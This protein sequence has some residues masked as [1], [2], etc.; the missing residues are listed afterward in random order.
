M[1]AHRIKL[2]LVVPKNLNRKEVE[3]ILKNVISSLYKKQQKFSSIRRFLQSSTL[4]EE[5][6]EEIQFSENTNELIKPGKPKLSF[7]ES[8]VRTKKRKISDAIEAA[9][10]PNRV[11]GAGISLMK[12]DLPNI[13]KLIEFLHQNK[14][15]PDESIKL[16]EEN[17]SQCQTTESEGLKLFFDLQLSKDRYQKLRNFSV[18]KGL[19]KLIPTYKTIVAA[20]MECIPESLSVGDNNFQCDTLDIVKHTLKRIISVDEKLSETFFNLDSI[21]RI[22]FEIKTGMDG[23]DSKTQYAHTFNDL[24]LSDKHFTVSTM[25]PLKVFVNDE[26]FYLNNKP[27]SSKLTRPIYFGFEK[28]STTLIKFIGDKIKNELKFADSFIIII[29]NSEYHIELEIENNM[30]MMDQK[31]VNALVD[32]NATLRCNICLLTFKDFKVFNYDFEFLEHF[33]RFI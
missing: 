25:V 5:F 26:L 29:N 2:I 6:R 15:K 27:N 12:A 10:S 24:N 14:I 18:S 21:N 7:D 33:T 32:N 1:I 23:A 20:K 19:K 11:I 4:V 31:S 22:K 8:S 16:M 17:M 13:E 3:R 28:E 30:T 9:G